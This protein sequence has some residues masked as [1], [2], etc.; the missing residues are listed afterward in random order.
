MI[1]TGNTKMK[2]LLPT[3]LALGCACAAVP[4]WA[5]GGPPPGAAG[6]MPADTVTVGLGAAVTSSYDG[7]RSYK[8]IPGGAL[9]GTVK[10]HDFRLTGL[11]LFVDAIPNAPRRRID[12]ELGP[13]VG[14]NLNRTGDVADARVAALGELDTAVELGLRGSIGARAVLNRTDKLA[15]GVTGTWDVAGAHRSHVLSPSLEYSTLAGRRTFV[16][17]AVTGEF[18]GKRYANYYFGIDSA[19]A[20]ASGLAPYKAGGGLASLGGNVLVSHSLSGRRTGWALFGIAAYKRWQGDIAAS[21]IVR[22]TG[23]PNQGFVSLGL[24]YTF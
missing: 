8:V 20:A 17:L 23:S 22:D 3:A 21:P 18:V 1:A 5:Q 9:Q 24:A 13:V 7:A 6:R 4:A 15:L 14:V 11:Q 2:R 16:R 10:G 12:V 19:G